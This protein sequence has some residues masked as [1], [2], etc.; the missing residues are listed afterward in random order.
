MDTFDLIILAHVEKS[1]YVSAVNQVNIIFLFSISG[2]QRVT[3]RAVEIYAQ[4]RN[5]VDGT[6]PQTWTL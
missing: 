3:G 5:F 2:S 6:T 4:V 1:L